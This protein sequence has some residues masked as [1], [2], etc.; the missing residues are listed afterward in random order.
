MSC[1]L[2]LL[3]LTNCEAART[4]SGIE[5]FRL[6]VIKLSLEFTYDKPGEQARMSLVIVASCRPVAR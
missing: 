5:V 6:T 2:S 1:I 4:G 3:T